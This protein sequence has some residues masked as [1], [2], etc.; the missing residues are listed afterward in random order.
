MSSYEINLLA[1]DCFKWVLKR[2]AGV[3]LRFARLINNEPSHKTR[4]YGRHNLW[5]GMIL[6]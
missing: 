1:H 3:Q 2:V 6:T 4:H 5:Q